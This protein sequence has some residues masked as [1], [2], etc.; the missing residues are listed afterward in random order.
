MKENQLSELKAL[1]REELKDCDNNKWPHVCELQSTEKGY[2]R[3]EEMIIRYVAK[4]AM[5]IGSA[6]ALIEQ[7]LAH[8]EDEK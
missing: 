7:E 3:I 6:I 2:A 4:E 1:I 8:I 5:P